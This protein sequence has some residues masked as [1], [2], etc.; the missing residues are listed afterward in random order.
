MKQEDKRTGK[1]EKRFEDGVLRADACMKRHSDSS[2]SHEYRT[3]F[4]DLPER[5]YGSSAA[6]QEW[7]LMKDV[8]R[9]RSAGFKL[10]GSESLE[11]FVARHRDFL[12]AEGGDF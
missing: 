3:W 6:R 7:Y 12:A 4:E 5:A 11:D 10:S 9:L 8:Y 2:R 1:N